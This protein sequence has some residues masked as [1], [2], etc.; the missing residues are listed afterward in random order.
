[1][2]PH[3]CDKKLEVRSLNIPLPVPEPLEHCL[4]QPS[5]PQITLLLAQLAP[6]HMTQACTDSGLE[7]VEAR[8]LR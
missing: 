4:V 1:V 7:P 2:K 5:T 8:V 6:P 3:F